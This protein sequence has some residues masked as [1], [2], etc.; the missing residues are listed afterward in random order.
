MEDNVV[1]IK[2]E[3]KGKRGGKWA[4]GDFEV[5][6]LSPTPSAFVTRRPTPKAVDEDL[7]KIPSELLIVKPKKVKKSII[8]QL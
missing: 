2:G 6:P 8:H 4:G 3:A 5:E 1:D 7:Y